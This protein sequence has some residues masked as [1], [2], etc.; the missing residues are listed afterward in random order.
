MPNKN[1]KSTGYEGMTGM[2]CSGHT[3]IPGMIGV[4]TRH[5]VPPS[6][7][8]CQPLKKLKTGMKV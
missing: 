2:K 5:S 6:Y 4:V 7:R 8:V 3:Y 1:E